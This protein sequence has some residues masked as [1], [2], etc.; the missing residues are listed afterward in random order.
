MALDAAI[1][2]GAESAYGVA[3]TTAEGYEGQADS[4]KTSREFMESKG[5]RAG[6]QTVR[7]DRRRI[8]N[9]G[10]EGELEVDLLDSGAKALLSSAF[11][12]AADAPGTDGAPR[13]LTFKTSTVSLSPSF[14]AQMIRPKVD[15]GTVVYRHLGCVA[16]EWEFTQELDAPLKAKVSFDFQDVQHGGAALPI[17]YPTESYAYDW[18]RGA[19][20]LT[21][22]GVETLVAV[23]KWTA[24]GVR[25]LKTDRRA[26]RGN[27]LKQKP[28]R[29]ELPAYEGE[30]EVEF[31]SSTLGLYEAFVAG[32]VLGLRIAYTGVTE[33]TNGTAA[34][35]EIRAPSIQFTGESPE[36]SLDDL[37]VMTLPFAIL[38]GSTGDA[39]TVVYKEPHA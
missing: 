28:E 19:V 35:L 14:T 6:M 9:M 4:W 30:F 20:Y 13:T 32:E 22:A 15:G 11:D 37:T 27:E 26:I 38:H 29:A 21:R 8:V 24:K 17:D 5:F 16:T 18:T 1:S 3:A 39:V 10:G 12:L 2:I 7:A 25:G 23:T 31:T 36:A 34:S 33:S